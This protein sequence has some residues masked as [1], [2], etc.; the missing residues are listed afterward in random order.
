MNKKMKLASQMIALLMLVILL[1]AEHKDERR[2][3]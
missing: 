1:M 3:R 2:L